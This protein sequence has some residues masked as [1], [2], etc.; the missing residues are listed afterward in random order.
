MT[1]EVLD[2]NFFLHVP[3]PEPLELGRLPA[4]YG[5]M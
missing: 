3:K 4:Y 1:G 2:K 5:H